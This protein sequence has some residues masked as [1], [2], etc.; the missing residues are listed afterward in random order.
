MIT[1]FY[2]TPEN[3][4]QETLTIEGE[5][6][7]HILSVMRYRTGDTISVVDGCGVKYNV[8]I[9]KTSKASLQGKILSRIRKENEPVCNI[10]LAQSICRQERMDFLIEKATEIGVS[11]VIPI[12]TDRGLVK[13]SGTSKNRSK[14]QRWRRIAVASM[15]Q[16]LRT[17]LPE[18]ENI[19][20]FENLLSRIRSYDLSLIAS[21][22]KGSKSIKDCD[23]LKRKVRKILL[24]V[25]PEAGFTP[26]ELLKAKL[27]GAIPITLG[28]RRLRTE[29]AGIVLL[30]LILHH[31]NELG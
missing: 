13:V 10:T 12:L 22:E 6:A 26:E 29:T 17:V 8:L 19:T 16:S 20:T 4:R 14:T 21:L 7:K 18:I 3:I 23:E 2:T 1:N 24:I 31:L 27:H 9:E 11:S 5:E 28:A 25:G 15:K 30:S